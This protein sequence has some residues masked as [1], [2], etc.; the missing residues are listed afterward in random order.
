MNSFVRAACLI[1]LVVP[2]VFV[3]PSVSAQQ[4]RPTV[5]IDGGT[6][7]I[8]ESI[9]PGGKTYLEASSLA[10]HAGL[11]L[12]DR[13]SATSVTMGGKELTDVVRYQSHTYVSASEFAE[14]M[15]YTIKDSSQGLAVDFWSAR[16]ATRPLGD[17]SVAVSV[18]R[19]EKL[20]SA[21]PN[22]DQIRFTVDMKNM[23]DAVQ[24][25]NAGDFNLIDDDR[26]EF[27]CNG[28]FDIGLKPGESKRVEGIYFDFPARGSM[29]TLILRHDNVVLGT[30]RV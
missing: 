7:F 8:C 16:K 17:R 1:S 22:C 15:G 19:T 21:V 24:L 26:K 23:T 12:V 11:K 6:P 3:G 25:L 10:S 30:S 4:V 9:I 2:L 13:A 27:H 14:K 28:T 20:S 29:K 18:Y 5:S